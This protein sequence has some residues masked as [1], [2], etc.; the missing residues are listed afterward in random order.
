MKLRHFFIAAPVLACSGIDP[1]IDANSFASITTAGGVSATNDSAESGAETDSAEADCPTTAAENSEQSVPV[2]WLDNV[3][4][5]PATSSSSVATN[6]RN[7]AY[8]T[9]PTS[10]TVAI[11]A[12]GTVLWSKPFGTLVA[13]AADDTV[14]VAGTF[15]GTLTVD[16]TTLVSSG[17]S[18][19]YV[20]SMDATGNVARAVALG[21]PADESAESFAVTPGGAAFVSGAGLGTVA[22]AADGTVSWQKSFVGRVATDAAGDLLVT[23]GFSGTADFGGEPLV[24]AGGEDIFVAKLDAAGN[25]VFS[26]RYGDAGAVQRGQAIATDSRGNI[27][28]L[29]V[30]E[31]SV[32]F[33][34]GPLAPA[35]CPSEVWCRESGFVLEL[36]ADGSPLFSQSR[37]PMRELS[38]VAVGDGDQVLLSG[39]L[40]G[41][42]Q[43][44]RIPVLAALAS[45]G[46]ELWQQQEW[47]ET[48]LGA[49]HGVAVDRCGAIR[50]A[51]SARPTFTANE[52]GY[53]AKL[54]P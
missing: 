45:D 34:L 16:S 8:M 50:W 27:A 11:A 30:Y 51:V 15:E 36:D 14:F 29:G 2:I 40:P 38:S 6:A 35:S 4:E 33:G 24:S 5:L 46:T 43:P 54:M 44:Y 25:H 10:G 23:G 52:Q 53:L 12:D 9:T 37:G 28:L 19:V 18:D 7:D 22:L 47:P 32:D 1:R 42:A 41:N 26:Q 21:G 49:G 17:G 48:G 13:V 31:G 39:S 20:V 3:G